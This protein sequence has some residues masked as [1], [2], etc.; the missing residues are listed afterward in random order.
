MN[1]HT[2]THTQSQSHTE[3]SQWVMEAEKRILRVR[4]KIRKPLSDSTNLTTTTTA[5]NNLSSAFEK[6]LPSTNST[7]TNSD[8][9]SS[10]PPPPP[11]P[12]PQ[13]NLASSPAR[14]L[15][16]SSPLGNFI[17]PLFFFAFH[18]KFG[19]SQFLGFESNFCCFS[20]NWASSCPYK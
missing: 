9:I 20:S 16:S 4:K 19:I 14:L 3:K 15:K 5:P 17:G 12:P 1:T 18:F 10:A 6:L 7:T 8:A 2:H 13:T 11:P